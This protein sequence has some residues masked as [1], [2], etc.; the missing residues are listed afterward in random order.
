MAST[1]TPTE[2]TTAT[3]IAQLRTVLDLTHTEIQVAETRVAQARTDA[4]RRELT[5]NAENARLRAT[6]IEKTIR[7]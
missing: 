2:S 1:I 4:V 6:T 7:D 5:Q 3:L